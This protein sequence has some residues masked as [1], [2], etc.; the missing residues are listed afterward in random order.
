M[1]TWRGLCPED[2]VAALSPRS[3]WDKRRAQR[4]PQSFLLHHVKKQLSC[5]VLGLSRHRCDVST[6]QGAEF[7]LSWLSWGDPS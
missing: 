7:G 1:G 4:D 6:R 5:S 2:A 3:P